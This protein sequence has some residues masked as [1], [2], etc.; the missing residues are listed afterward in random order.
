MSN[1]CRKRTK[2]M[3][4]IENQQLVLDRFL[5]A[6]KKKDLCITLKINGL[7]NDGL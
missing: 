2:Q 1:H 7:K 6:K 3:Q 4:N 5:F